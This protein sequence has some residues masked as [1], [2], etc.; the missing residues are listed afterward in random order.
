MARHADIWNGFGDPT[1]VAE[2]LA[3]LRERCAEIGREF[4]SIKRT[5]LTWGYIRESTDQAREAHRQVR[6]ANGL[7]LVRAD[8]S[9]AVPFCAGSPAEVAAAVR[10]YEAVGI[11]ELM[12]HFLAP[13]DLETIERLPEL[14]A[15]LAD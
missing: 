8:G 7:P 9:P 2:T 11:G 5:I 10:A 6:E 13:F 4:D 14:R 3:I 1:R 15:A 12:W